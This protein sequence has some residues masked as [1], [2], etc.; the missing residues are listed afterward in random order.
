MSRPI[1]FRVLLFFLI[2][3]CVS[4]LP[5][6]HSRESEVSVKVEADRAFAT[7]GDRINFRVTAI[8]K[9]D[10]TVLEI[11]AR[12]VLGDFEIKDVTDFSTREN[13]VIR[14]GK[15]YVITTYQL[16]EF[17]IRPFSISYRLIGGEVKKV[18]TT[19]LYVTIESV[20]KQKDPNSDI[21]GVKGVRPIEA[22]AWR[23]FML[24]L[25]A[26][27]ITIFLFWYVRKRQIAQTSNPEPLLSPQ[28]EAYQALNKLRH[29]DFIRKGQVKLYFFRLS[30][31]LRRY[32]ERRYQIRALES[33]TY[34]L[35]KEL[36]DAETKETVAIIDGALSFCDLV[37]FAKYD[38]GATEVLN[39][40]NQA[41]LIVDRTKQEPIEAPSEAAKK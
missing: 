41:K 10:I 14:E 37:K 2:P 21:R 29:S 22:T 34:E 1:L 15:N 20:D 13:S 35:M 19:P 39:V 11:N 17:V 30:E 4:F 36:E 6:S 38:P 23:W 24:A 40:S 5:L 31:I 16:G 26:L 7:I 27:G 8:H 3:F 32:F 25:P 9:S 12:D 33:T 18:L 28:D